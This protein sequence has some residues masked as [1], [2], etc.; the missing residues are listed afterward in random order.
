MSHFTH[1]FEE[2]Y[3]KAIFKLGQKPVRKV[4]NITLSRYLELSPASVLEMVRKLTE[5]GLVSL[6]P[7]KSIRLTAEGERQALAIIRRHR[8]WEVFLVQKLGFQWHEV[9]SLAEELEHIN[10]GELTD[11]LDAFLG[12][13]PY[14][15]HG[16]PIPDRYGRVQAA[17]SVPLADAAAG[18]T[19]IIVSFA[20]TDDAFLDYLG[21]LQL[22]PGTRIKLTERHPY[23]QSCAVTVKKN[24]FQLSEK[25]ARNILVRPA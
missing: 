22:L 21:K 20:E 5:R 2:N 17:R 12:F 23:D 15:P 16:D 25:V 8:L 18:K 14:D 13:P 1:H 24:A 9:H 10:S 3:L 19:H 6:Q 4:N 11:R 7:D